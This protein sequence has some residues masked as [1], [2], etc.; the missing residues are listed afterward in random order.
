MAYNFQLKKLD[1]NTFELLLFDIWKKENLNEN[2]KALENEDI[3]KNSKLIV[4]VFMFNSFHL[5]K[6]FARNKD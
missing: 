4:G 3:S 2:I 1:N 5:F 6:S